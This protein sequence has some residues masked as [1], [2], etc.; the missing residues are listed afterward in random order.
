MHSA[1][2][3]GISKARTSPVRVS[4]TSRAT[5]ATEPRRLRKKS[6]LLNQPG[7]SASALYATCPCDVRRT[8]SCRLPLIPSR[9]D[10]RRRGPHPQQGQ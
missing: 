10:D 8:R 5:A 2:T 1:A 4:A 9:Q 7:L 6:D 3:G